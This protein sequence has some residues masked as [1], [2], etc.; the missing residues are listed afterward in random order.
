MKTFLLVATAIALACSIAGCGSKKDANKENFSKAI[1]AYLDSKPGA[2]VGLPGSSIPFEIE[3]AGSFFPEQITQADA[4]KEAG[5]LTRLDTDVPLIPG[6]KIMRPGYKFDLSPEGQKQLVKPVSE[7]SPKSQGFCAGKYKL[8]EIS[9][10]TDAQNMMGTM[11][12]QAVYTYK[13]ESPAAWA[14]S[15]KVQAAFVKLTKELKGDAS[16]KATL[17]LTNDGWMHDRLFKAR[18]G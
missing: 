8:V 10:F 5:L 16:D 14:Q 9:N 3:K 15:P 6:S 2:C 4:L 13:V 18:G 12:S 7:Y 17:I 1:Q 11:V